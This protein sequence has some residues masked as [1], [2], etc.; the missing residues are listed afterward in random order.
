MWR[1]VAGLGLI[2]GAAMAHPDINGIRNNDNY[3]DATA[4]QDYTA[5]LADPI[6][7]ASWSSADTTSWGN[8]GR[9]HA[10][11]FFK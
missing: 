10:S 4:R 1:F 2:L 6:S 8:T 9:F 7:D 11:T 5:P 3:V